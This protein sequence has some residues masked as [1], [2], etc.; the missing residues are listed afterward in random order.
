MDSQME[1]TPK[2][3]VLIPNYNYAH[4]L[5]EAITS[6]LTQTLQDFEIIIV[7][8]SSTDNSDEVVQ[9]Y[10]SDP[11]IKYYKNPTNIGTI[12]N[13]NKCLEYGTGEYIKFLMAD[14]KFHPELLAKF[15][16]IMENNPSVSL[17]TSYRDMFGLRSKTLKT[18]FDGFVKGEK[19]IYES[20]KTGAGNW[21][22]EPSTVMFRRSG[23]DTIGRFNP[24]YS[25]LVDLNLWLRLLTTGDA[26]FIPETLSYFRIHGNQL[27]NK[28][29]F[30]N[31]FDEYYFYKAAKTKNEYKV[32]LFNLNIDDIIKSKAITCV[33]AMFK[34]IP[35]L[36]KKKQRDIVRKGLKVAFTEHVLLTSFQRSLLNH[37]GVS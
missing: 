25:C 28:N 33:K 5:D 10:L 26:Y 7:D 11:R 14:D 15:S 34:S 30:N 35:G 22:G 4:F 21:I 6:V 8:N 9:K 17:V 24:D 18:I 37:S 1:K 12:P 2:V 19:V 13:F 31:R 29:N 20:L 27:S 16:S 3:S 36:Y 23:L 32:D